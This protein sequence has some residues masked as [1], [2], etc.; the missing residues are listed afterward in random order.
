MVN[1]SMRGPNRPPSFL[2]KLKP[3]LRLD[4]KS[5][6]YV[7]AAFD[8]AVAEMK[9]RKDTNYQ[10]QQMMR[11]DGKAAKPAKSVGSANDARQRMIDRRMKKEDK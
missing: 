9:T 4:G 5:A 8:M 7:S 2:K 11:G 6:A 10:R 3:S 1:P